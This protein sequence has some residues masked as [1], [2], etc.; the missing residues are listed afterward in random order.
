M[1]EQNKD[2]IPPGSSCAYQSY[3]VET[4]RPLNDETYTRIYELDWKKEEFEGKSVLDIGCNSG[5]LSLWAL[6][7]GAKSVTAYDVQEPLIEFFSNVIERN[8][9]P[10]FLDKKSF[11]ELDPTSDRRDIVLFMEVLH[12]VVA[13]GMPLRDA[14][15]KVAS[16][17]GETL[18]I[19]TPWSVREPSIIAQTNL[20]EFDYSADQI[21][22][23]L[24]RHFHEVR[25]VRFMHYFGYNSQSKRVLI[26]AHGPRQE[27]AVLAKLDHTDILNVSLSLGTNPA[28]LLNSAQGP[29]VLKTVSPE[30]RL[31]ILDDTLF[32]RMFNEIISYSST[33]LVHPVQVQGS[34]RVE[35]DGQYFMVFPFIGDLAKERYESN[36]LSIDD[37]INIA[38]AV[39]RDLRGASRELI[40]DLWNAQFFLTCEDT[41]FDI[42]STL[43]LSADLLER[44]SSLLILA[45]N[46]GLAD[47]DAIQHGDLQ[48]GNIV[49]DRHHT[50]RCV[51][52]DNFRLGTVYSDMLMTLAW[53]GADPQH[54]QCGCDKLRNEELRPVGDIDVAIASGH[55]LQW[56][57][58]V[59]N[60]CRS[61]ELGNI[62]TRFQVGFANLLRW[63]PE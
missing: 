48:T 40:N 12:W 58:T 61:R 50:P 49:F 59:L 20:N 45:K 6:H 57:A 19:E 42:T 41:N 47:L 63:R 31:N 22:E 11:S 35:K 2:I 23:E 36:F 53:Q 39:R 26:R 13:Q 55:L 14:L 15:R 34:F 60:I 28:V 9:L 44:L 29:L 7:L 25:V 46:A 3:D 27:A 56:V 38:T 32:N 24:G 4:L 1:P 52:L 17:T 8:G 10:I 5:L 54:F 33:C 30:S 18:Y 37:L 43:N 21:L 51:D 16:L 62:I